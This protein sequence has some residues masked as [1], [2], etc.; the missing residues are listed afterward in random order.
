M[1]SKNNQA[2]M[3]VTQ[4]AKSFKQPRGGYIK[5]TDFEEIS[6]GNGEEKLEENINVS[7][8]LIGLAIDYLTRFMLTKNLEESFKISLYGANIKGDIQLAEKLLNEIKGLDDKSISNAIKLTGYDVIYRNGGLGYTPIS[9]INPNPAAIKNTKIMVNRT[10]NFFDKYGPVTSYGFTFDG[11]Y[12]DTI[13]N[14]DGDYL[15]SDTLWDLK[16]LKNNFTK[17]NTLQLLIYWRMGLR[18]DYETFKNIRYLGIYNPR[19]NKVFRYDTTNINREI[20]EIIDKEVIGYSRLW[21][22]PRDKR[23]WLVF[24]RA[25]IPSRFC[26]KILI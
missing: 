19:K 18:S 11:A 23:C 16:V 21:G 3:T 2:R 20:L 12:T 10:L 14:G 1:L 22:S 6:L 5:R 15:T 7:P 4:R 26:Y 13:I 9:Y 25:Q 17:D 8:S 24:R